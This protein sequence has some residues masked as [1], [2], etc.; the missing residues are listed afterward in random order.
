MNF[1]DK[2][3]QVVLIFFSV[4]VLI[5]VGILIFQT[6]NDSSNTVLLTEGGGLVPSE[7]SLAQ[8]DHAH[9]APKDDTDNQEDQ[10]I[11]IYIVGEVHCPGVVELKY[12]SR[13]EDAVEAAG[14]LTPEAD[15]YRINLALKVQDEGMYVIPKIGEETQTISGTAD[16]LLPG[17]KEDG[18][19]NINTAS[20]STLETLP[21]IGA[22]KAQRIISYREENGPFQSIEDI[23]NV[24]GIGEKTY[25]G[26]KDLIIAQ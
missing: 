25:E 16:I 11:K 17:Q 22:V 3:K 15:I 12:G 13:L 20:L 14:G 23:K 6:I 7:S 10:I 26:L 8:Q 9:T 2:N 21:G 24:S 5:I 4:A 18:K 1:M 19:I